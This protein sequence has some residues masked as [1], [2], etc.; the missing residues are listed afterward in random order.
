MGALLRS[1]FDFGTTRGLREAFA[2]AFHPEIEGIDNPLADRSLDALEC[3]RNLI[4]HRAAIPNDAD[5]GRLR[6]LLRTATLEVGTPIRP[7]GEF[8]AGLLEPVFRIAGA[9]LDAVDSQ[10]AGTRK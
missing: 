9:L 1:R 6:Q 10:L 2:T 3:V 7:E 8:V 5:V 4:V